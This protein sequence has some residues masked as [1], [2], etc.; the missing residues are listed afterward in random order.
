MH[1]CLRSHRQELSAA[2]RQ[3]E[4]LLEEEEAE[5]VELRPGVLR[6]RR[7]ERK[8]RGQGACVPSLRTC[9][10]INSKLCSE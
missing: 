2:C 7:V 1:E 5:N 9:F 6:V 8:A 4:L 3:E 10:S